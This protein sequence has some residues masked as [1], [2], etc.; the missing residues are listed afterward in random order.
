MHINWLNIII[1]HEV[2]QDLVSSILY[3]FYYFKKSISSIYV[4]EERNIMWP[5]TL[6]FGLVT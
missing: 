5:M 2:K 4:K 1:L 6:T 3:V